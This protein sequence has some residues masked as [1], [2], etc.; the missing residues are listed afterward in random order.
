MRRITAGGRSSQVT[1]PACE[2][3]RLQPLSDFYRKIKKPGD[4]P[5]FLR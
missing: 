1:L 2:N 5:G 4:E 3:F